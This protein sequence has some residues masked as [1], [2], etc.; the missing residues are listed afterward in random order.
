MATASF[1][2][3]PDRGYFP[4]PVQFTDT[5]VGTNGSPAVSWQWHFG[6]TQ[7]STLQNPSHTYT[8]SA[9]FLVTLQTTFAD[10]EIIQSSIH[11][12]YGYDS[13]VSTF[14]AVPST[15]YVNSDI[16]FTNTTSYRSEYAVQDLWWYFGNGNEGTTFNNVI[17]TS[18]PNPGTFN[19][20]MMLRWSSGALSISAP[21][22]I[23]INPLPLPTPSL[24]WTPHTPKAGTLLNFFDTTVTPPPS[25][26]KLWVWTFTY[27]DG[28]VITSYAKNPTNI[29]APAEPQATLQVSMYIEG[30][31]VASNGGQGLTITAEVIAASAPIAIAAPY[32]GMQFL[33][34]SGDPLS[35][36]YFYSYIANGFG[37]LLTYKR[38]S[39][40]NPNVNPIRLDQF[41]RL[42]VTGAHSS[43]V[44]PQGSS[45]KFVVLKNDNQTVTQTLDDVAYTTLSAGTNVTVTQPDITANRWVISSSISDPMLDQG[46]T[47]LFKIASTSPLRF[48]GVANENFTA[49]QL[50]PTAQQIPAVRLINGNKFIFQKSGAYRVDTTLLIGANGGPS[51]HY[52]WPQGETVFGRSLKFDRNS[53]PTTTSYDNRYGDGSLDA[54][55]EMQQATV[56]DSYVVSASLDDI[57]HLSYYATNATSSATT[58]PV[59]GTIMI[60]R[61]GPVYARRPVSAF[62]MAYTSATPPMTVTFT[63]LSTNQPIMWSWDFGDGSTST[64]QNPVHIYNTNGTFNITFNA[65]NEVGWGA[66]VTKPIVVSSGVTIVLF[67]FDVTNT[68]SALQNTTDLTFFATAGQEI[69][70]ATQGIT[71]THTDNDSFIRL[72]DDMNNEI[73][74]NDDC[75]QSPNQVASY[76]SVYPAPYTGW[77]TMKVGAFG[78]AAATGIAGYQLL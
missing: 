48:D 13:Y 73:A 45:Y 55:V 39:D 66:P 47:Y 34:D 3:S 5:S 37:K 35:N 64:E 77:Y 32:S 75:G 15:T 56:S 19:A 33:D 63:D 25:I 29:L 70:C 14:D 71:G 53:Q 6:D 20:Q 23:T 46:E 30:N 78:D 8:R 62:D 28:T 36:G 26:T 42:L 16:V 22:T 9:I 12:V 21:T 43:V 60:T 58:Q 51:D 1:T 72:Y 4:L 50:L 7:I 69:D 65:G 61:I 67:P 59:Y 40:V 10:G 2:I 74:F 11:F 27:P 18:Y 52:N 68:N 76:C 31:W 41:G 38:Y 57:M 24:T 17:T 54:T 49:I 44:L